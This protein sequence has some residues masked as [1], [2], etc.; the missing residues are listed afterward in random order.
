MVNQEQYTKQ[1]GRNKRYASAR[2]TVSLTPVI[3]PFD[4][5]DLAQTLKDKGYSVTVELPPAGIGGRVGG[6]GTI[7]K[8][9]DV[10][11]IADSGR[12]FIGV[13]GKSPMD[14]VSSFEELTQILK[15]ELWVDVQAQ[16]AYY[17]FIARLNVLAH[18]NAVLAAGKFFQNLKGVQSLASIIGESASLFTIRLIPTGE[19]PGDK[20]WFDIR[21][22]PD[23]S[24]PE[25]AFIVEIV[26]RKTSYNQVKGFVDT[27]DQKIDAI[28]DEVE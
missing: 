3:F 1:S 2:I 24:R 25:N 12:R 15:D 18:G 16:S 8:R 9:G 20:E 17:E 13:D 14:V 10:S 11:I 23:V 27:I 4:F 6:A 19:L 5:A 7:A 28:L 22:E 26:Y 21:I